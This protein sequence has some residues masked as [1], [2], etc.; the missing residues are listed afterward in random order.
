MPSILRCHQAGVVRAGQEVGTERNKERHV[1]DSYA[2]SSSR[3]VVRD[4][5]RQIP[6]K[7]RSQCAV[8][9]KELVGGGEE[10][11]EDGALQDAGFLN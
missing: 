7:T 2:V 6:N 5:Q 1:R 4:C 3:V 8:A 9:E 10:S 11:T